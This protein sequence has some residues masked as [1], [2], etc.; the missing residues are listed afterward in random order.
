MRLECASSECFGVI[1]WGDV[2]HPARVFISAKTLSLPLRALRK[3]GRE[4][5][6]FTT[7]KHSLSVFLLLLPVFFGKSVW[8]QSVD[9]QSVPIQVAGQVGQTDTALEGAGRGNPGDWGGLKGLDSSA[10]LPTYWN[11]RVVP[12]APHTMRPYAGKVEPRI[13]GWF[14]PEN[15]RLR[16]DIGTSV[17]LQTVLAG[18]RTDTPKDTRR[19]APNDRA[20]SSYAFDFG[21]DFFTWTQLR[22]VGRFKFPVEAVDYYFGLYGSYQ[23]IANAPVPLNVRLRVA[24]ISAHLVDGDPGLL[25]NPDTAITYS[26]EFVDV[27]AGHYLYNH[28]SS[29]GW[30]GGAL[31]AFS[32]IPDS[33]GRITPYAGVEYSRNVVQAFPLTLRFGYEFRLNGE[34][35]PIGENQVRAGVKFADL[36]DSGIILE[37]IYYSG[38]SPYGQFFNR[39]ESYFSFGF[40]IEH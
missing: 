13:G 35:E 28:R 29:F 21:A 18:G 32:C 6:N 34:L 8:A 33:L 37:G 23:P 25:G 20:G 14:L 22:S 19:R 24:H 1:V 3:T 10:A 5:A 36:Y 9:I 2:F 11:P 40:S 16:L 15:D 17:E 31:W 39:R 7:M 38:R 4:W 12:D 26:R 30:Y 27:A